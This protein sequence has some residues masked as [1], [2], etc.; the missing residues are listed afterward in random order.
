METD[1]YDPY[2]DW[3]VELNYDHL[4]EVEDDSFLEPVVDETNY[5]PYSGCDV[6]ETEWL[7]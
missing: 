7:D 5:D 6:F 4:A 3:V 1:K 2:K